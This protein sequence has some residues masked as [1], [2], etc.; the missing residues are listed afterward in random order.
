MSRYFF[1]IGAQ[2]SGSTWLQRLIDSHPLFSCKGEGHFFDRLALPIAKIVT[3]YN[4][5]MDTVQ[6][7]VYEG[8]GYYQPI[9]DSD[10]KKFLR[11]WIESRMIGEL[12]QPGALVFGDK[13]PAYSFHL[14]LIKAV[15]PEAKFIHLIRDGRD[16]AVSAYFHMKRVT[17]V[18][19][20]PNKV[21]PWESLASPLLSKWHSYCQPCVEYS[22]QSREGDVLP[23][24]YEDLKL[25]T[26]STLTS[27]LEYLLGDSAT[28]SKSSVER[29]IEANSFSKRTGRLEGIEDSRSFLR[30]GV[31]GDWQNHFTPAM[32]SQC[33]SG[34]LSLLKSLGYMP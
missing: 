30:K 21:P 26:S 22:M 20:L 19:K 7:T 25:N 17:E 3:D 24:R 2:K 10:F 23:V 14:R 29:C 8:A 32:L 1:I 33:D 12:G 16:V 27:V 18:D 31:I 11:T 13:T 5:L 6:R 28:V 34:P 4:E 9:S 15:F